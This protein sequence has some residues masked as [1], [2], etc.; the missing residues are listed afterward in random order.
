MGFES[1]EV[2][3]RPSVRFFLGRSA[4]PLG[5]LIRKLISSF[6]RSD[7]AFRCSGCW[8]LTGRWAVHTRVKWV[9]ALCSR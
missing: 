5:A 3:H 7:E 8:K 9:P 6:A 2:G 1:D 4:S